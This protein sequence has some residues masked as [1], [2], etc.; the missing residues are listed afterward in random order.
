[1]SQ[2]SDFRATSVLNHYAHQL[3]P[4]EYVVP[5]TPFLCGPANSYLPVK[6][7][8]KHYL[9]GPLYVFL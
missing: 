7:Q 8:V 2:P 3:H 6:S 9:L 5:S 4:L 1:M